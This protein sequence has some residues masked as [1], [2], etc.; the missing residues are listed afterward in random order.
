MTIYYLIDK[1]GSGKTLFATFYA[2]LFRMINPVAPIYAN[3]KIDISNFIYSPYFTLPYSTIEKSLASLLIADDIKVLKN[4]DNFMILISCMSRKRNIDVILTGQYYTMVK[5]DIRTLADYRVKVNYIKETD[6]LEYIL[7]DLD[8]N[9]YYYEIKDIVK[10]IGK[11]FDTNEVVSIANER[12][13]IQ[14]IEK[15]SYNIDDLESNLDL[16]IKNK[17]VYRKYLR[18]IS[19]TK[20]FIES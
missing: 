11:K 6:V 5:K 19:L 12:K 16:Y 20:H 17:N 3:Y 14:E 10:T 8:D 13:I 15:F 2:F 7:I 9:N 18:E 4:L 1:M